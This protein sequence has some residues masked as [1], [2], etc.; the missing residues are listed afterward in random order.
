MN[1]ASHMT[2]IASDAHMSRMCSKA[3]RCERAEGS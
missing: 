3:E 1:T 2:E